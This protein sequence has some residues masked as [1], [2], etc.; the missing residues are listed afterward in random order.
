[1]ARF[2]WEAAAPA[3]P[4]QAALGGV[5]GYEKPEVRD[6]GSIADHTYDGHIFNGGSV[7]DEPAGD[8]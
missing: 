8:L 1:V 2:D 6:Y 5:V 4:G 7:V 3:V